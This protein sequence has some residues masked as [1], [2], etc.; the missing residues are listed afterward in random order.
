MKETLLAILLLVCLNFTIAQKKEK[1]I[2]IDFKTEIKPLLDQQKDKEA[3]PLL[4]RYFQENLILGI[5]WSPKVIILE[6][7]NM[8]KSELTLAKFYDQLAF[9]ENSINYADTS[10]IWYNR[11]LQDKHR[12][13]LYAKDRINI[14]NSSKNEFTANQQK[15][16]QNRRLEEERIANEKIKRENFVRD[17]IL[18]IENEKKELEAYQKVITSKDSISLSMF[19]V[20]YPKSSYSQRVK[21]I[22]DS[23][24]I[25]KP[26][27]RNSKESLLSF[28]N[29][30]SSNQEERI[31]VIESLIKLYIP[32]DGVVSLSNLVGIN[33]IFDSLI[34]LNKKYN[35]N[36]AIENELFFST[37]ELN[38]NEP[39]WSS[40]NLN[41]SHF[42]NGDLIPNA[43]T[44][45]EWI[46]AS[47]LKQPAW[48]YYDN[49]SLNGDYYSKLYNYYALIDPRGIVSNNFRLPS[50]VDYK[51][52]VD[53]AGGENNAGNELKCISDWDEEFESEKYIT[54]NATPSGFRDNN[55]NFREIAS[56]VGFWSSSED[57]KENGKILF[58]KKGNK[59]VNISQ[60]IN[61]GFGLSVRLLEKSEEVNSTQLNLEIIKQLKNKRDEII[62]KEFSKIKNYD[63]ELDFLTKQISREL[64][65]K[66]LS[67]TEIDDIQLDSLHNRFFN[68]PKIVKNG[69]YPTTINYSTY[70]SCGD[71]DGFN[72]GLFV[73]PA[74][75]VNFSNNKAISLKWENGAT[76]T[77]E[78]E[79]NY[80][81]GKGKYISGKDPETGL[82]GGD[83]FEG[84]FA[85]GYIATGKIIYK[86]KKV[87]SGEILNFLPNGKGIMTLANG[88]K[89][90]G[91]FNMGE[92][93]KPYVCKTTTIGSQVW[94]A[95]NLKV[96]KFRNGDDIPE[97][98]TIEEWVTANRN[99]SAAF[100]YYNND[101]S[102]AAKYGILYNR[103]AISD[104]RGLA[105]DGWKIPSEKDVKIL[106]FAINK[107]YIQDVK[108]IND[109]NT[110]G[111]NTQSLRRDLEKKYDDLP[112]TYVNM[113][114]I[115]KHSPHHCLTKLKTTQDWQYGNGTNVFGF[116]CKPTPVRYESGAFNSYG[117]FYG[118]D[119]GGASYWLSDYFNNT[120]DG[121]IISSSGS[122]FHIRDIQRYDSDID[123]KITEH[124]GNGIAVRCVKE[125]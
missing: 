30:E 63:E 46:K 96:T 65:W 81:E 19:L 23:T 32:S 20:Q 95:E 70:R 15:K 110:Q 6:S 119:N 16:E 80:P 83:I 2:K 54:F 36:L 4:K 26:I 62:L 67:L 31:S 85:T 71:G 35:L 124:I 123:I 45:E 61:K 59:S 7:E 43:R 56:E 12:D 90:D 107:D 9:V 103:Y 66:N 5:A 86:D 49:D 73:E 104:E 60:S 48:C 13:S 98:K 91:N 24:F 109:K 69:Y 79:Y 99:G 113:K 37:F 50:I 22:Y 21:F 39:K 72:G 64:G 1:P 116:N 117:D 89:Q 38:E 52:L 75:Q 100:C 122:Y 101:P 118:G 18:N 51:K 125:D 112:T 88:Q 14:L 78:I 92:F 106:N 33:N 29:N 105:P 115:T 58:L 25:V 94:M 28:L 120:L 82:G 10:I 11:M 77:G 108:V 57:S 74:R 8:F 111:I 3:I 102:T 76:Y 27:N 17:S 34:Y 41:V 93:I 84:I 97:A 40:R 68:N 114:P 53:N 55:G 42:Q 44:S 47:E 87:Y 121:K